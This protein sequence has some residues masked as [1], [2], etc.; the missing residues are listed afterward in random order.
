MNECFVGIDVSKAQLD[1]AVRPQGF[2]WRMENT[3]AGIAELVSKVQE[4]EPTGVALEATGGYEREV[5]AALWMARLPV[6]NQPSTSPRLC[7]SHRTV[8]EDGRP[9]RGDPGSLRGGTAAGSAAAAR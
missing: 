9:R 8:S 3:E 1:V 7:E 6:S 4:L 5:R 2:R